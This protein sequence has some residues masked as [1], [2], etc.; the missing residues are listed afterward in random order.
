MHGF[1]WVHVSQETCIIEVFTSFRDSRTKKLIKI[2]NQIESP[3]VRREISCEFVVIPPPIFGLRPQEFHV[4]KSRGSPVTFAL[5]YGVGDINR[6]TFTGSTVAK[7]TRNSVKQVVDWLCFKGLWPS[8]SCC[9]SFLYLLMVNVCQQQNSNSP[10]F[11]AVT[12]S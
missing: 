8:H 1:A 12:L 3:G 2:P 10:S 11:K 4:K 6:N 9:F 5:S 7:A